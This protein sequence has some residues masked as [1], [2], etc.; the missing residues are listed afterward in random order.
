MFVRVCVRYVYARLAELCGSL[1]V[2]GC[3]SM[4]RMHESMQHMFVRRE[5]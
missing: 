3:V 2:F 4:K 1:G 5:E